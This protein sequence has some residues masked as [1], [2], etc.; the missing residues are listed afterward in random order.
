M[1][2]Q[3]NLCGLR[4]DITE[5]VAKKKLGA[6]FSIRKSITN[7]EIVNIGNPTD[8]ISEVKR[9]RYLMKLKN[10]LWR[11]QKDKK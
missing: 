8:L 4:E 1:K 10:V 11:P 9:S 3:C 5:L 2:G 6:L 7:N